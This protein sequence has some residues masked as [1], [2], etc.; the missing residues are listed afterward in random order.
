MIA[1]NSGDTTYSDGKQYYY[2][3]YYFPFANTGNIKMMVKSGVDAEV[4]KTVIEFQEPAPTLRHSGVTPLNNSVGNYTFFT[5][6]TDVFNGVPTYVRVRIDGV[7]YNM[8]KNN[9]TQTSWTSG[10]DYNYTINF[11]IG[12]HTY[13]FHTASYFNKSGDQ[14]SGVFWLIIVSEISP[15]DWNLIGLSLIS[16]GSVIGLLGISLI[17]SSKK[18]E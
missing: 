15:T 6:F 4:T 7:N 10:V 18:K 16:G 13:E 1:N 14:S 3:W 12:N 5:N 8:G 17:L 9:S 2:N 11:S